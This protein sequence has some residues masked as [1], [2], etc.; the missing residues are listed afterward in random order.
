MV[1]SE[2]KVLGGK[3]AQDRAPRNYNQ[4]RAFKRQMKIDSSLED[5]EALLMYHSVIFPKY[6]P[7]YG[8]QDGLLYT[9]C[10]LPEMDSHFSQI[11]NHCKNITLHYDTTFNCGKY[12]VSILLFRHPYLKDQNIIPLRIL[13]H[14]SKKSYGHE[15]LFRNIA[16]DIP[17]LN[18]SKV[19]LITDR[20]PSFRKSTRRFLPKLHHVFCYIHIDKVFTIASLRLEL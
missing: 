19:T 16:R 5:P 7:V 2:S 9:V 4:V 12:Y 15:L 10:K 3:E 8:R 6:L 11:L 17:H 13:F 14:E 20:E 18:S 1:R